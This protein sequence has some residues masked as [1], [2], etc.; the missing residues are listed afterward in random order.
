MNNMFRRLTILIP[1][2][3]LLVLF[4]LPFLIVFRISISILE[5]GSPPYIPQ[6]D[7]EGGWAGFV[8]NLSMFNLD[9]YRFLIP[10]SKLRSGF[11]DT[12]FAGRSRCGRPRRAASRPER[13]SP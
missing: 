4:L 12:I 9:N 8:D 10:A 6:F 7:F 3:W 13:R 11:G 5:Y 1:Y 2:V